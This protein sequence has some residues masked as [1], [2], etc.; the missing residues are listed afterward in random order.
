MKTAV[1]SLS[2][3]I[4]LTLSGTV[5]GA[6]PE[7][8]GHVKK[9]TGTVLLDRAGKT[10]ALEP[11]MALQNGDRIR[12]GADGLVGVTL[13][14]DTLLSAGKGSS[15]LINN[16]QFD[17]KTHAGSMLATLSK[18]SLHV[19]TGLIA[20]KSPAQVNFKTPS[21]VLGVRGTDFIVEVPASDAS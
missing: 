1:V 2:L 9:V 18:G 16:F 4:A 13:A 8:I 6:E 12:T 7:P 17:T 3:S 10:Q 14:D 19:V 5:H 20:K 11:G 15:L 21:T